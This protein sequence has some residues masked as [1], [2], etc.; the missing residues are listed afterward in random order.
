MT[1]ISNMCKLKFKWFFCI[2]ALNV[3]L[4]VIIFL[5]AMV[6]LHEFKKKT[7]KNESQKKNNNKQTKNKTKPKQIV[8]QN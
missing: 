7:Y 3:F 5:K 6:Q 8:K 1:K 4:Y 2:K